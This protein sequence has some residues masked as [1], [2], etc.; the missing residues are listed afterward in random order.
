MKSLNDRKEY[1]F[2]QVTMYYYQPGDKE[3][4][5]FLAND[6]YLFDVNL[7]DVTQFSQEVL[8]AQAQNKKAEA[9]ALK[10]NRNN[11]IINPK[12]EQ[13]ECIV[14]APFQAFDFDCFG[15]TFGMSYSSGL[16]YEIEAAG[17]EYV[18]KGWIEQLT[19]IGFKLL[20]GIETQ[21]KCMKFVTLW[22]YFSWRDSYYNEWDS[23]WELLGLVTPS[24][25]LLEKI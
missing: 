15:Q 6:C 2:V 19:Q 1:S 14:T 10:Q 17:K 9:E 3:Y 21:E 23:E 22:S 5:N 13:P 8:A 18:F 20:E 4:Y 25:K 12:G 24:L 11:W 7:G 16:E